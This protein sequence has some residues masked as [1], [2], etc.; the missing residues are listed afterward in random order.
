MFACKMYAPMKPQADCEKRVDE[1]VASL[2]LQSCQ[3]TKARSFFGREG[4]EKDPHA[5]SMLSVFDFFLSALFV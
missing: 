1:V 2:G 5:P 4:D 3:H